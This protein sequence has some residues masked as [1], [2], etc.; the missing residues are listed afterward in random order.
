MLRCRMVATVLF[1]EVT[2]PAEDLDDGYERRLGDPA[3]QVEEAT[4]LESLERP[5]APIHEPGWFE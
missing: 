3:K 4:F 1:C 2:A 5:G